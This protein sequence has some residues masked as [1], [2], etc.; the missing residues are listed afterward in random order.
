M[1]EGRVHTEA[2]ENR[3]APRRS[4]ASHDE[5][6]QAVFQTG[7]VEIH[8]KADTATGHSKIGQDLRVMHR[9]QAIDR[10]DLDDQVALNQDV[11]SESCIEAYTS[12][13]DRY[14]DLSPAAEP[15]LC[16]FKAKA[17]FIDRLKQPRPEFLVNAYGEPDD[18]F[19]Q[20]A[21]N[22]QGPPPSTSVVLGVLRVNT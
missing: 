21:A 3:G 10:L 14:H 18:A 16:K 17:F 20:S 5:A 1:K 19:G 11:G 8:Q 12:V 9:E 7:R 6:P 15:S 13:S 2:T 4:C 22:K